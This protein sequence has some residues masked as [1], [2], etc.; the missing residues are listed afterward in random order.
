MERKIGDT[1]EFEGKKLQVKESASN[2][3][4]GCFFY[5]K[6]SSITMGLSG[7]CEVDARDDGK[8]VIFVEIQ[9]QPHVQAEQ[10]QLNLC[11]ILKHCPQGETF[12]SPM[13]D[14]VKFSCID[15]ERQMII[16]ETIEGHF[17]WE[18]NADGTISIDEVTSPEVMLYPSKE[19]RDWSK[20]TAPWLKK[21]R[22][23]PQT[24]NPFDKVLV[25]FDCGVWSATLFS[26]LIDSKFANKRYDIICCGSVFGYCI[27]YNDDTKHLVGTKDEAPDF[28]KYWED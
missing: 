9:E 23:D 25:R 10:P 22:F 3:C 26:H 11:E 5:M 19:M 18:I 28:Y 21:E 15:E 6:C 17:T 4:D 7:E 27:P 1:F 12:W 8:D 16:V 20:F 24:L 2:G 13:L 14:G